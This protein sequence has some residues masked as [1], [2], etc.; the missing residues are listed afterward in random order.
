MLSRTITSRDMDASIAR[1]ERQLQQRLGQM[2]KGAENEK[3]H[4]RHSSDYLSC[5]VNK[6][7]KK[8]RERIEE[9]ENLPSRPCAG[10]KI[11]RRLKN[12]KAFFFVWHWRSNQITLNAVFKY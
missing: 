9:R 7:T 10:H 3:G 5:P 1:S 11:R 12:K 6:P 4:T 2:P 8:K